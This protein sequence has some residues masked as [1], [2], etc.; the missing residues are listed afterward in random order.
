MCLVQWTRWDE[1]GHN[2]PISG[3]LQPTSEYSLRSE[4]NWSSQNRQDQTIPLLC[5]LS[6]ISLQA[7]H[8]AHIHQHKHPPIS[9]GA[10][11]DDQHL[12][13]SK[14]CACG[15]STRLTL[16]TRS[17]SLMLVRTTIV[18]MH[19]ISMQVGEDKHTNIF[20]LAEGDKNTLHC[21][22]PLPHLHLACWMQTLEFSS[23]HH[24][25]D[26]MK[27]PMD[28]CLNEV[29]HQCLWAGTMW[30]YCY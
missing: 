25:C 11:H 21:W 10:Q 30:C 24:M 5:R 27:S 8:D 19:L 3:Q 22:V 14:H 20:E 9:L 26:V 2:E 12:W 4:M 29:H 6:P 17:S 23:S 16:V 1:V 13:R 15:S 18:S 7:R 28:S